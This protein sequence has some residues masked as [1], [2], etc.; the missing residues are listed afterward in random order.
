MSIFYHVNEHLSVKN[1]AEY[2]NVLRA[3]AVHFSSLGACLL[4]GDANIYNLSLTAD[5]KTFLFSGKKVTADL[6]D[7]L[8]ALQ[9]ASAVD[10]VADYGY[11][12]TD[13]CPDIGLFE[14]SG[15]I[16][17]EMNIDDAFADNIFYS[18]YNAADCA[19]GT[20]ILCAYGKKDGAAYCGVIEPKPA[21]LPAEGTWSTEDTC[22]VFDDNLTETMNAE[23][24]KRCA[25][26]YASLG[27]N[28]DVQFCADDDGISLFVNYLCLNTKADFE[29]FIET[30]QQLLAATDGKAGFMA[31]F[32]CSDKPDT[33]VLLIDIAD[34]GSATVTK[35]AI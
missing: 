12:W 13:G 19:D 33:Q 34:D 2:L 5:D 22:V 24:I 10:L 30:S 8:D 31:Q 17:E 32:V 1:S 7:L 18:M 9:E 3:A 20:G 4:R 14:F 28:A 21:D 25:D 27:E 26:V 23:Q 16:E 6:Q 35:A 11:V 29:K 15:F